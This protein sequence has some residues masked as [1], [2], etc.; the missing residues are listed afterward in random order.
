MLR[1]VL[2]MLTALVLLVG[3]ALPAEAAPAGPRP[4]GSGARSKPVECHGERGVRISGL[5]FRDL[6]DRAPAITVR[7][8]RDVVIEDNE[9]LRVAEPIYVY[10]SRNVVIR[11]NR[12][13]DITG[14]YHR[15]GSHRGN[16]TQWDHSFGGAITDN[17]G[18]GG[19]TEDVISLYHSGGTSSRHPL[20]IARNH[21]QG[22]GWRSPSGAGII[23]GDGGGDHV[24]V[25]DNVLVDV[26]QVGIGIAGGSDI[27]VVRNTVY[28]PRRSRSNVG[29]YVWAQGASCARV[30]VAHNVIDFT[31]STGEPAEFWDAG[32]CGPVSGAAT[33]RS[34]V[35]ILRPAALRVRL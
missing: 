22:S 12:Y 2:G 15:D 4:F 29:I 32:N 8:C 6:D 23:V 13:R 14:P 25:R 27:R 11:H 30:R 24:V 5:V 18:F 20:V 9:F 26:G 17:R 7:N 28:G 1:G 21:F 35:R 16:F 10:G 19:D 31:K 34:G 33:N 3:A